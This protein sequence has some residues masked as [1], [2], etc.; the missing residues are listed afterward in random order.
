[1]RQKCAELEE[2]LQTLPKLSPILVIEPVRSFGERSLLRD[3]PRAG[4]TVCI[5]D[6]YFAI[7][8]K[9]SYLRLLRKVE[10]EQN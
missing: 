2:V 10:T 5:T 1:M 6:C 7:V 3:L 4:T 9:T 8:S